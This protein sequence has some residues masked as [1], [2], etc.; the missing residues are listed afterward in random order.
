MAVRICWNNAHGTAVSAIWKITDRLS[1]TILALV[2]N[3]PSCGAVNDTAPAKRQWRRSVIGPA[4]P[5]DRFPPT[6]DI[7]TETLP[8]GTPGRRKIGRR[9][10]LDRS[11]VPLICVPNLVHLAGDLNPFGI[12]RAISVS[13]PWTGGSESPFPAWCTSTQNQ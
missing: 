3:R 7:H 4:S 13:V 8:G 11:H 9:A 6:A 2:S 10:Y 1:Q 5:N 12:C